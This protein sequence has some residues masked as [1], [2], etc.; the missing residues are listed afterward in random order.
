[1]ADLNVALILR[2]VDEATAPA[3]AALR[4]VERA[5]AGMQRYGAAQM[6]LSRS[7]IAAAQDHTRALGGEAM[8]LAATGYGMVKLL[9]PAIDFEKKMAEVGKVVDF[10]AENGLTKLGQDIQELVASGGLPMAADGIADIVAAAAQANLIDAALPDDEKRQQLVAFG[11]AAAKMGVAFDISAAQAGEAMATWRTQLG[12]DQTQALLLGDA[13]NH[14]SNKMNASAGAVTDVI[15]RSGALAKVA[16]LST[17]EIAALSA[18]FVQAAPSPEIAATALK[19]FT[20]TLV[21]GETMTKSQADVMDRLGISATDLAK[22]M[23]SDAQGAILDVMGSLAQLPEYEQSAALSRLFGQES[24]GAIAP[25]LSNLDELERVFG[26]VADEANYAGAMTDEYNGV[27]ST[28]AA[29]LVVLS[30]HAKRLATTIG[31]PLLSSINDLVDALA[32]FLTMANNWMEENP[33]L[34]RGLTLAAVGF[35]GLRAALL[36]GRFAIQTVL[37]AYWAFN[38]ALA[39]IIWTAGTAVRVLG[40]FGSALLWMGRLAGGVILASL[41]GLGVAIRFVGSALMWAGRVAMA[42]PLL[43]IL[44]GIALAAYAIYENWDGFVGYFTE[45]IDRVRAAFDTGLLNGVMKLLSEFNPF[46]MAL[47]GAI[48]L[49][50]Y[51]LDKLATAFDLNLFDK[52][53][54]MIQSLKDGVWSVLTGMVDAIKAKLSGIVPDWMIDAWNWVKG[55]EA[56]QAGAAPATPPGRALGGPVRAGQIYRWMEEGAEMFSPQVDG[57][58]ISTRELRALRA[59][60][61]GGGGRSL[62]IG[63][64][65]IHA[66]Q[67]QSPDEIARAVWRRI[68]EKMREGSALH[69]GGAYA[70]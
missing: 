46:R 17:N 48:A 22:R 8:A 58:V 59:P 64:I 40:W 57:S 52:G 21:S 29:K 60:G 4:Q 61:G 28:T 20:G 30:N 41:R 45:K 53:A 56:P 35:L 9:Q 47:D 33:L 10:D 19:S 23:R 13:V 15:A 3:R 14:L 55:G 42:N 7:Q 44:S 39:A 26:L 6:A 5:G 50:K 43:L 62:S 1:M 54:A 51:V 27:A 69:D 25:L 11:E 49:A 16:G 38:G 65:S 67:G 37:M 68:E 2:L 36:A 32:P 12:L 70:D 34:V 24:I 18:A 31:T 66:A 63:E